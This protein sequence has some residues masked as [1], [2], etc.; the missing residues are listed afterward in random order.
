MSAIRLVDVTLG[1]NRHPAVHH[2]DGCFA[3]GSMTAVVGP[4]GA[5]KSTV[6]KGIMGQLAPMSGTITLNGV[7]RSDIAYLPQQADIDHDFPLSVIDAVL[8]GAWRSIGAF[9]TAGAAVLRQADEA[10]ATVGLD[11]FSRRP[12]AALSVGQRQRMLFARLLL[13]DSPVIL[14][15]EPFTAIDQKTT[16]DLLAL[17]RRWHSDQ[18]TV[19]AV[20]H[21]HDHVRQHFPHA[22]LL[23]REPIAWGA[24]AE[25]L[26]SANLLKARGMCEAWD[27]HA[28]PCRRKA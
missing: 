10:L 1:Y 9:R 20:L 22:L 13:Q 8:L 4:N 3:G 17:V 19:I 16:D 21:D 23:A 27:D 15:D 24:T 11:G 14:L 5:G 25:V 2:L 18:R 7:R 6:L 28:P 12:I 26:T